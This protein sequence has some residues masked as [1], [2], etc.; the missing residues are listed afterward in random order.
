M[1]G[2]GL[3]G[4]NPAASY[5]YRSR[6]LLRDFIGPRI[7]KYNRIAKEKNDKLVAQLITLDGKDEPG[8]GHHQGSG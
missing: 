8:G 4:Y 2:W 3:N 6:N 1:T 5:V 7:S